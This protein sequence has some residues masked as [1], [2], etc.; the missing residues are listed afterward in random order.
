MHCRG[1]MFFYYVVLNIFCIKQKKYDD[2][3]NQSIVCKL[4][5]NLG[6]IG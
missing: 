6:G 2:M 4:Y 1:R 5:K 3:I